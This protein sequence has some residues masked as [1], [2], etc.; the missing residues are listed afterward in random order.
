MRIAKGQRPPSIY[1]FAAMFLVAA[2]HAY[3]T[4]LQNL[5]LKQMALAATVPVPVP[6]EAWNR[7]WTIVT[8][9]AIFSIAFIPVA[10]IVLFASRVAFWLVTVF[11][12]WGLSGAPQAISAFYSLTG[13]VG[14]RV[15][16]EP[17]L[18][19]AALLCLWLPASRAWIKE[20]R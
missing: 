12:L 1:A 19:L 18:L 15:M 5:D 2:L 7:D 9:S 6:A 20:K 11:T 4:G 14:W 17:V 13:T 16:I 3:V 8:L 10:W